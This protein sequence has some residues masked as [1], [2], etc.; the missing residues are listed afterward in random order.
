MLAMHT[1]GK[2]DTTPNMPGLQP[3]EQAYVLQRGE[4]VVQKD[5][6]NALGPGYLEMLNQMKKHDGGLIN[7]AGS[8]ITEGNILGGMAGFGLGSLATLAAADIVEAGGG[9]ARQESLNT[10]VAGGRTIGKSAGEQISDVLS[11]FMAFSMEGDSAGW[12]PSSSGWPRRQWATMSPNTSAARQYWRSRGN[13]PG[14]IGDDVHRGVESSDHSWGKALDFMV[15]PLGRFAQGAQKQ[16]GWAVANWHLQNPNAFGTNYVIWDKLI[17]SGDSR[18]WRNYGRYG[19]NPG[20]TLGHYDH[21]HVSY[22]HDGGMVPSLRTGGKI[23]FDNT[24]ANLHKGE[25]VLTEPSTK[26]LEAAI[27]NFAGG[28]GTGGDTYE[29][30]IEIDGTG[31][32]ENKL[33]SKIMDKIELQEVRKG[34]KRVQR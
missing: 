3:D 18:G 13:F 23:K 27:Q 9:N 11:K 26:A 12:R 33:A 31:L 22:M 21:V 28:M 8:T 15:A 32:D 5:A 2:I 30:N 25:R 17:N 29:I 20:A 10:D 34:R 19:P 16:L 1:G 24:L 14:G 4:F 6:V 7:F